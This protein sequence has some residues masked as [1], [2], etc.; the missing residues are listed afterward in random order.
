MGP[1]CCHYG[2]NS[3]CTVLGN[4]ITNLHRP[5]KIRPK[6]SNIEGEKP[7]IVIGGL[8]LGLGFGYGYGFGPRLYQLISQKYFWPLVSLVYYLVLKPKAH[9]VSL[10]L[11]VLPKYPL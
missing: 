6:E 8:G 1:N 10:P 5:V 11:L 9:I 2:S 7:N 4:D 3:L